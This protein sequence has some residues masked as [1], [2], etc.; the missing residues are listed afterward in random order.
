MLRRPDEVLRHRIET[1]LRSRRIE[2][3]RG[4]S[5]G[6]NQV[7]QPYVRK[8][9]PNIDPHSFPKVDHVH[10]FGYYIGNYPD[11]P[12]QNILDLCTLLNALG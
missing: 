12:E 6:G 11:L 2:F 8:L 1:E 7:R 5:G 4:T 10:F 3:R 9:F